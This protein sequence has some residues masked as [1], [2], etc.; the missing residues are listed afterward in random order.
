MQARVRADER[1]MLPTQRST[2]RVSA[3]LH[4]ADPLHGHP[5]TYRI[6]PLE[7]QPGAPAGF[8]VEQAAGEAPVWDEITSLRTWMTAG[9]VRDL[10]QRVAAE[11][12]TAERPGAE[13]ID[14]RPATRPAAERSALV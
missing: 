14:P 11:R 3:V 6:T 10:V 8:L 13:R 5:V 12:L 9:Q 1:F 4:G 7:R 2:T